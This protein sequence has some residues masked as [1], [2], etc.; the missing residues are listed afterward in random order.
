MMRILFFLLWDIISS[1]HFLPFDVMSHSLF[2]IFDI[3]SSQCFI[4]FDILSRSASITFVLISF[5]CHL[6]FDTWPFRLFLPFNVFTVHFLSH[7]TFCPSTF[8]PSEFFT[9]TYCRWV[10]TIYWI[11]QIDAMVR[12][13]HGKSQPSAGYLPEGSHGKSESAT[14]RI[15]VRWW[16]CR[17]QPGELYRLDRRH[18]KCMLAAWY[19]PD[20]GEC[21]LAVWYRPDGCHGQN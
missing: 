12:M 1:R 5:R 3:I 18:R 20:D 6:P 17:Y 15:P 21:E 14:C 2:I 13:L 7:S 19:L 9:S 10:V 11:Y 8:L 4:L 16:Y